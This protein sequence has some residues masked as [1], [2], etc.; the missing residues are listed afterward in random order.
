MPDTAPIDF[1]CE[2]AKVDPE[3]RIVGGWAYVAKNAD[4]SQVVD[5][6]G[7]FVEDVQSLEDAAAA[8]V[9]DS[10]EGDEMHTE[11]VIAKLVG[12]MVFTREK[13]AAMGAPDAALPT[14]WWVEF[15]VD[16]DDTWAKVKKGDLAMFSIAGT[17]DRE[18]VNA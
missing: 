2:I 7:E 5:H 13:L 14:G 4:G 16:S 11:P 9:A 17:A 15:R 12:S 6:S 1:R 8:F 3:R 10:R 18:A